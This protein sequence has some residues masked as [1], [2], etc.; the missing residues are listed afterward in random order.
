MNARLSNEHGRRAELQRFGYHAQGTD[1]ATIWRQLRGD[2]PLAEARVEL[3]E[4]SGDVR[5]IAERY[6][7]HRAIM[8]RLMDRCDEIHLD[9][10]RRGPDR[11]LVETYAGARDDYEDAVEVFGE[12]RV[13]LQAALE[14]QP[15]G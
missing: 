4:L 5:V 6:C 14:N 10:L 8:D 12:L 1:H 9:I 11:D 2:F 3:A 15:H 7:A 13:Q